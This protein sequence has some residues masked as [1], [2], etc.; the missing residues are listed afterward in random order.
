MVREIGPAVLP[1]G[2]EMG[3]CPPHQTAITVLPKGCERILAIAQ[4]RI[5]GEG[6]DGLG[7]IRETSVMSLSSVL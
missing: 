1:E 2:R 6:G 7:K 4:A 5:E 3:A